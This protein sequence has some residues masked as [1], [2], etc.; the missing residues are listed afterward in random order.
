IIRMVMP[1]GR[2]TGGD[3]LLNG[4]SLLPLPEE[5]MRRLRGRDVG[6]VVQNPRASLN[7]V[8]RVGRQITNVIQ[9]HRDVS[10]RAAEPEVRPMLG[11][12]RIADRAG[13]GGEYP[14][15]LSGGMAQR[16][17]IAMALI[18]HPRLLIADEPTTGLDVTVQSQVMD[19]LADLVRQRGSSIL[20]VTHDLA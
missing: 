16:V 2:I 3:V 19:L 15:R 5:E 10:R 4:R 17:M 8:L 20:L 13:V 14:P 12:V 9:A 6:I 18:N 1:P 7:P 11:P